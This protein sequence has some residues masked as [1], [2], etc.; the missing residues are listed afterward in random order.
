M[1][2]S[3]SIYFMYAVDFGNYI[4]PRALISLHSVALFVG[5]LGATGEIGSVVSP[6]LSLSKL[7]Y[8]SL[9]SDK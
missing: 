3:G 6:Y 7:S 1:L 9:E 8:Y 5:V 2:I 4:R